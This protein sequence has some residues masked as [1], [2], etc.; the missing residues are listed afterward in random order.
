[1]A[2]IVSIPITALFIWLQRYY[3]EG[4]TGGSVKG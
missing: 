4:V 3:V 2:V 1:A